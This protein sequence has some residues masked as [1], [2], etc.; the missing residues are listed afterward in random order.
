MINIFYIIKILNPVL[1]TLHYF[2]IAILN[3]KIILIV[4]MYKIYLNVLYIPKFQYI[5]I[6]HISYYN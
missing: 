6:H 3:C 4:I 5:F 2:K 1:M